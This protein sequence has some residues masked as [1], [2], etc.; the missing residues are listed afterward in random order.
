MNL[1]PLPYQ[2]RATL[3]GIATDVEGREFRP[4]LHDGSGRMPA[5]P[6]SG[7]IPTSVCGWIEFILMEGASAAADL[8]RENPEPH[9]LR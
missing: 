3:I 2:G 6:G 9:H 7:A 5:V 8:S 4:I 1:T